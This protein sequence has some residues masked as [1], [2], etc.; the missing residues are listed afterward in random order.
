M[1]QKAENFN[2]CIWRFSF[3]LIFWCNIIW[4]NTLRI[5]DFCTVPLFIGDSIYNLRSRI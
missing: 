2:R 4:K 3:T 5:R 1:R